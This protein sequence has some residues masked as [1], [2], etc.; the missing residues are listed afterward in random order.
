MRI[1]RI[2][3]TPFDTLPYRASG[4]GE[5]RRETLP[6]FLA[7]SDQMPDGIDVIVATSDLQGREFD[8]HQ[9]RLIGEA[10]AER[11]KEHE[12]SG[13]IGEV[14]AVFLSGDL[15]DSPTLHKLGSSGD[16]SDVHAA[17]NSLFPNVFAVHGNH[18]VVK[19]EP[20]HTVVMDGNVVQ[21]SNIR[22]GGVCGIC[23][24]PT[25]NQRKTPEQYDELLT[26]VLVRQPHVVLL[27]QSPKGNN[28][29]QIGHEPT[30]ELLEQSGSA[31][32]V[33][34]HCHWEDMLCDI[35]KNQILNVDSRVVVIIKENQ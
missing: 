6:F 16:V 21:L 2:E 10:V 1:N 13:V 27:H 28:D 14:G 5:V 19:T 23:G 35:G 8:E 4:R 17:F 25:K 12:L 34:G 32:I 11:L 31:L 15:Y 3:T 18:D 29:S 26:N 22:I 7:Y 33:S 24:K 20:K 9:N 30:R